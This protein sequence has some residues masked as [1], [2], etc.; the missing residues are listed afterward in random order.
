MSE[1]NSEAYAVSKGGLKALTHAMAFSY[2]NE[3][4]T[5]NCIS[6]GWIHTGDADQLHDIYQQQQPTKRVGIPEDVSQGC[7]SLTD[8]ANDFITSENLVIDGGMTRKMIYG[9]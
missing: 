6:H 2:S 4:I 1:K 7:L 9:H 3:N 8:Y 5:I